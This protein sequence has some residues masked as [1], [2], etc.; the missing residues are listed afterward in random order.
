MIGFI[1]PTA[2]DA[3]IDGKD[4]RR[5]MND[6]YGVMGVCPQHD[7]LWETLTPRE[8]LN[9]YGRL[10]GLQGAELKEAVD[11]VLRDVK[12]FDVGNKRS[13][14]FSGGAPLPPL[15][16]TDWIRSTH[17]VGPCAAPTPAFLRRRRLITDLQCWVGGHTATPMRGVKPRGAA[18]SAC[19][20]LACPTV[21]CVGRVRLAGCSQ[22]PASSPPGS[23][24]GHRM[25]VQNSVALQA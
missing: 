22:P 18:T 17:H 10:K 23:R 11:A 15:Q 1:E 24:A 21:T 6:I 16:R 12:L 9:F 8:H 25:E 13:G 2:G 3:F 14:Q 20:A 19:L 5:E 4:L 7:L